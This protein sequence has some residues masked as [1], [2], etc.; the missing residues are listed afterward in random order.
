MAEDGSTP[1]YKNEEERIKAQRELYDRAAALKK[2]A[3]AVGY[4][5]RNVFKALSNEPRKYLAMKERSERI[6]VPADVDLESQE[7]LRST[8]MARKRSSTE[9][10][11]S[12]LDKATPR[13]WR[14]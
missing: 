11:P 6:A 3:D 2:E 1:L 8:A 13:N 5:T 4:S 12:R 10:A 14:Q 9:R 7:A